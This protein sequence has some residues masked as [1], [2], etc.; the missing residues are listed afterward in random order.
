MD[1]DIFDSIDPENVKEISQKLIEG[2]IVQIRAEI[3]YLNSVE[4]STINFSK[5][6]Q[7]ALVAQQIQI[8]LINTGLK[9]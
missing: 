3:E 1:I 8:R 6:A 9:Y 5:V 4:I 2:L 7:I